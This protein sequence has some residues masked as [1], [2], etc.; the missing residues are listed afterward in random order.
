MLNIKGAFVIVGT[1]E[2]RAVILAAG[3]FDLYMDRISAVGLDKATSYTF[4]HTAT[5]AL[6]CTRDCMEF[7]ALNYVG[8]FQ[9]K[10]RQLCARIAL[11]QPI[12]DDTDEGGQHAVIDAPKPKPGAP[13]R[14]KA[15]PAA[16]QS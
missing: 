9:D 16:V 4:G 1:T 10:V 13:S 8:A 5:H 12:G 2:P 11:G 15:Q 7:I 3:Q 6:P 14:A